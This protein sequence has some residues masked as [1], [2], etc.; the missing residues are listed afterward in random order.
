MDSTAT[1]KKSGACP[2][3]G[4]KRKKKNGEALSKNTGRL[5]LEKGWWAGRKPLTSGHGWARGG[6]GLIPSHQGKLSR[7][8]KKGEGYRRNFYGRGAVG[9]IWRKRNRCN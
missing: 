9:A 2:F 1:K 3:G 6:E 5:A 4:G 7:E 8:K